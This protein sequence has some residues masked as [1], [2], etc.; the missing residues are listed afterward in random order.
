MPSYASTLPLY[1]ALSAGQYTRMR[2]PTISCPAGAAFCCFVAFFDAAAAAE[3]AATDGGALTFCSTHAAATSALGAAGGS[4][5]AAKRRL[6][7]VAWL[8]HCRT[9]CK[10]DS[11][12]VRVTTM[13][14]YTNIH[15]T[16]NLCKKPAGCDR[17]RPQ[18]G[19][20]MKRPTQIKRCS[21]SNARL[22]RR[23]TDFWAHAKACTWQLR[24]WLCR[25]C[26]GG[27]GLGTAAE[28]GRY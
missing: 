19:G 6:N 28:K 13:S 21:N 4:F 24:R 9:V 22:S 2:L 10:L 12:V 3:V 20:L 14:S 25:R 1:Q 27:S 7:T 23:A 5:P 16:L 18:A 15:N 26:N 8:S 11:L 17:Q